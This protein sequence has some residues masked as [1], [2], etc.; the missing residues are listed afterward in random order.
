MGGSAEHGSPA[1]G[2]TT[3]AG[4]Q[5]SGA[6]QVAGRHQASGEGVGE[7]RDV[8]L[9]APGELPGCEAGAGAA[10]ACWEGMGDAPALPA[11]MVMYGSL[12]PT[13][14]PFLSQHGYTEAASFAHT[15]TEER[16]VKVFRR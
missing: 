2:N 14:Q 15:W 4:V 6:A 10:E 13:I 7:D 8:R 9:A 5:A 11:L 16:F 12:L 3:C 1:A